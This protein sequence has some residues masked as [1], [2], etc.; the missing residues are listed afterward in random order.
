[1]TRSR[2]FLTALAMTFLL[3]SDILA[4]AQRT[5]VSAGSGNDANPCSR[6]QPCRNF[7]A[8]ITQTFNGGEVVVLDSGG[9]GVF[10]IDKALTVFAPDGVYAGITAFS[11]D[12]VNVSANAFVNETVVL[13]GL[14]LK[15]L[16]GLIGINYI[17]ALALDVENCVVKDFFNGGLVAGEFSSE[18]YVK[19]SIFKDNGVAGI[20]KANQARASLD[21]VQ[22][23]RNALGIVVDAGHTVI[24]DSVIVGNQQEGV[25]ARGATGLTATLSVDKCAISMNSIGVRAGAG[26]GTGIAAVSDSVISSN[27]NSGVRT[28]ASGTARVSNNTITGNGVGLNHMAGTLETAGNNAV[29]GN[30]AD[31]SGTIT[32]FGPM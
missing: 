18:L 6:Q 24:R 26:G 13:R 25:W 7:S 5:F 27:L 8:A 19:D 16:G 3:S 21:H 12:A 29:R 32:P 9:Y 2:L 10:T 28:E 11:G 30:T 15:G 20:S 22:L 14:T 23:Q 17:G 1:M 4:Q 31:T